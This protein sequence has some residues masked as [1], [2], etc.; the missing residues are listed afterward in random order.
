MTKEVKEIAPTH[1]RKTTALLGV[2]IIKPQPKPP[3]FKRDAYIVEV[4]KSERC[5]IL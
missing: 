1:S 5:V 2:G 4:K 3:I